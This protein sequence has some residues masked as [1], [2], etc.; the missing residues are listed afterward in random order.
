MS[1]PKN[2]DDIRGVGLRAW[3]LITRYELSNEK[4]ERVLIKETSHVPR[5]RNILRDIKEAIRTA[6]KKWDEIET[7]SK[8]IRRT[9]KWQ[10]RNPEKIAEVVAKTGKPT[11]MTRGQIHLWRIEGTGLLT[12]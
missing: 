1:V 7:E 8:F 12:G 10:V 11:E 4:A 6:R 2:L 5:E 3:E 9:P